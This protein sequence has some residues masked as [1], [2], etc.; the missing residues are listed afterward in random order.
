MIIKFD[1]KPTDFTNSITIEGFKEIEN[2]SDDLIIKEDILALM[3]EIDEWECVPDD[4]F[5]QEL[6]NR[7]DL[8]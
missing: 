6:D 8:L 3:P 4:K 2:C 5:I 1:H 7:D